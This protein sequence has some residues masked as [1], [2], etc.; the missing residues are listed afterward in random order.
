MNWNGTVS[1]LIACLEFLLLFKLIVF[2]E[3]NKLN[4]IAIVIIAL[5]AIY[6]SLEFLICGIELQNAFFPFLAFI[7]IS[8]LPPLNLLLV[9]NLKPDLKL[10]LLRFIIFLPALLF[11]I[12][13][14]FV[15]PQFAVTRC[16]VLYASYNYPLGDLYGFFYYL[17]ILI[18][19][20][21][22]I[23][24]IKN[25][26]DKK[27]KLV[28]KVLLS[29]SI[30]ISLPVIVGFTLMFAGSY[31][32]ISAMESVMCKFAFVYALCLSFVCLYNSPFKDERNY[33][34][35]LFSNK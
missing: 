7:I 16:T 6:Q 29:G 31:S 5:L 14:S 30:F 11:I 4:K 20:I 23:R 22:L 1:L 13:Y 35:Y 34:K 9:I 3:K 15:I 32:L 25:E 18:S 27:N 33:F 2:T 28:G 17:P 12:Y 8:F 26:V 24:L 19:I 21:L 10:K